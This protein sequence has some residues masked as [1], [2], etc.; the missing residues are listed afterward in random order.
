MNLTSGQPARIPNKFTASDKFFIARTRTVLDA[1]F[2]LKTQ[3]SLVTKFTP[4]R[5]GVASFF[6]NFS[7]AKTTSAR[8]LKCSRGCAKPG[9]H[10]RRQEAHIME[11][12]S[13]AYIGSNFA[14]PKSQ[15]MTNCPQPTD[16]TETEQHRRC[17]PEPVPPLEGRSNWSLSIYAFLKAA[18]DSFIGSHRASHP[19]AFSPD[20]L[21]S[22]N[23]PTE[24]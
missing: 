23:L 21:Q 12:V 5:A 1:G 18:T 6:F 7:I 19:A 16:Q 20:T 11:Q 15:S 4:L 3:G 13:F 9:V 22:V 10:H 8:F 24:L 17:R 2:A 14:C